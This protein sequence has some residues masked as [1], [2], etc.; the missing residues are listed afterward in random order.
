MKIYVV[1]N[2][3]SIALAACL[4]AM[5]PRVT[6]E[7]RPL[8]N[9]VG[10]IADG[11][12]IVRQ[13]NPVLAPW[14]LRAPRH[15]EIVYPR[16]W[17]NAFHPD[18]VVIPTPFR[19]DGP[20]LG[21]YYS[22]LVLYAWHRGLDAARTAK[23]FCE[24]VFERLSF[25][26]YWE[27]AKRVLLEEGEAVGFP[28]DALFAQ[29]ERSGTFMHGPRIPVLTVMAAIARGVLERAGIPILVEQP[30]YYLN[31]PL[32]THAIWPVYPE[33]AARL[34]VP[35]GYVF[36]REQLPGWSPFPEFIELDELIARSFEAYRR[37][38]PSALTCARL[39]QPAYRDLERFALA[40]ASD[41][42]RGLC[43]GHILEHEAKNERVA[44]MN[45]LPHD[46]RMDA[47]EPASMRASLELAIPRAMTART[48]ITVPCSVRNGGDVALVTGGE[49]P[50]YLC[51]RWYDAAGHP[52]EVGQA[53]HTPLP[54]PLQPGASISAEMSIA[55][56]RYAGRYTLRVALLQSEIAWFDDVDRDNGIEVVVEVGEHSLVGVN[57]Q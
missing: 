13:R 45:A 51:Y 17:F 1:G 3:Q 20:P 38:P 9:E 10:P 27:T 47:L 31:D 2:C 21:A 33:I 5:N 11:D 43:Y 14:T 39:E 44:E 54:A 22:S 24:P 29:W 40:G 35:G 37:M 19:S 48:V 32:V 6:V 50:I 56:P 4:G 34:G 42:G 25:F 12:L 52:V 26:D 55:A 7:A 46:A 28:L 23:L 8:A 16:V 36:K 18:V 49:H 57:R 53:L 30:E 15:D 41:N